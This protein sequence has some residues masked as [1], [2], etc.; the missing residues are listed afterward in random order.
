M[1]LPV[2][3]DSNRVLLQTA[4]QVSEL[5]E[6]KAFTSGSGSSAQSIQLP[7]TVSFAS[8]QRVSVP[9]GQ[10]LVM[11]GYEREQAQ[12]DDTDVIRGLL[13]IAKRGGR[14]KQGTVILIT[15]RL[16]DR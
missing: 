5:R 14:S 16:T 2:I 13:P 11:V 12:A 8:L 7:N 3:L 1:I 4:M 15:P 6:I 10:T 9:A